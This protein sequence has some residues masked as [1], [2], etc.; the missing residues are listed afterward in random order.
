MEQEYRN[1][2]EWINLFRKYLSMSNTDLLK[3]LKKWEK[4]YETLFSQF[5]Q[6]DGDYRKDYFVMVKVDL[7]YAKTNIDIIKVELLGRGNG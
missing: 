5:M 7:D 3:E 6:L 1:K 4:D 2:L